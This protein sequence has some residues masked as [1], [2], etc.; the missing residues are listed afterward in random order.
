MEWFVQFRIN[1]R[2]FVVQSVSIKTVEKLPLIFSVFPDFKEACTEFIDNNIENISISTVHRFMNQC[3]KE[4]VQY[5]TIFVKDNDSNSK[6]ESKY[7]LE[8]KGETNLG[9]FNKLSP[10]QISLHV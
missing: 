10:K 6:D 4:I 2:R 1:G 7:R 8:G 5:N 3:L 9:G